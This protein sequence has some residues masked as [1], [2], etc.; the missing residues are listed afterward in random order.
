[1]SHVIINCDQGSKEWHSARAGVI[2]AS[3]FSTVRAKVNG[4]TVQQEKYVEA[5]RAGRSE[6]AAREIAGYKAAPKAESIQRAIEGKPVGDWSAAA[7]DYAFR[8]AIERISGEPLDEGH[9][10]WSMRRGHEL[11]PQA[12]WEHE[13]QSGLLVQRAGFVKTEDGIFGASADGLIGDDEGSEYKCFVDPAKLRAFWIDNDA[14]SVME[15]AQGCMWLT[16]RK[17]WHICLY[18]PALEPVE[19]QL[20]WQVFERDDNFIEKM[21]RDLLEF[22][23]VVDEYEKQMRRKA[24]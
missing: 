18:C 1:M 20:W 19:K 5:I 16:G 11:E 15:Q 8:L 13:A 24:A 10:T 22:K 6:A 7:L 2:T 12:R 3:M 14:S 4:L 17:R 9:E 23:L 21:E